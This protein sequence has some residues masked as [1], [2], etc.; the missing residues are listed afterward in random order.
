MKTITI[1]LTTFN[2]E[3][4]KIYIK[5]ID[6]LFQKTKINYKKFTQRK[7]KKITL[8]KSPHVNKKAR[9][10]FEVCSYKTTLIIESRICS[11]LLKL[12]FLNKPKFIKL[13]TTYIGR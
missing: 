12:I 5:F 6:F 3:T 7:K 10:Q 13:N 1:T 11:N 8:L 4:L 2:L 9:E